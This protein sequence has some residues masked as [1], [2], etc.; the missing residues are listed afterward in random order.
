MGPLARH[1]FYWSADN[2]AL[3]QIREGVR[4]YLDGKPFTAEDV[5][6]TAAF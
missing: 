4:W 3:I 6:F 5:L 1:W 2:R